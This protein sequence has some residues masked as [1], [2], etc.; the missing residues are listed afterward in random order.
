MQ[1]IIV[2][3]GKVGRALTAQLSREDNNV[4]VVDINA[5]MVRN[6]STIY[7]VMGI[8]GNGTSY[9]VLA[10]A[11]IEHT[12]ILI[13]VTHSDE[14]NLL[15][16]VVA[17]KAANCHTIARIRNPVYSAERG[18]IRRELGLSMT[19][20]PEYAA[21]QE[22]ARLLRFPSAIDIDSFSKG[23]IEMLRFKVP[24]SS[25]LIGHALKN[26]PQQLQL[27]VLVCAAERKEEV[28][29]PDGDFSIQAG[30]I[31]SIIAI[32]GNAS[33]FFHRIGIHT[34]QVKN[35]LIIGGGEITY[36]LT[37]ILLSMGIQV[38]IIEKNRMRC[39]E[40]SELLPKA[41]IIYGDGSDQDLL[42]EEHLEQMDALVASTDIDEENIILSLYAK[43]KV[44]SKV[45]TK[46]NHLDFNDVIHSLNLD[47]LIYPKNITAEYILQ[48][49]RAMR[50]S[51][52]SNVET[53]YKLMDGRVEALEFIINPLSK[54]TGIK[55][56][57]MRLK[58]NLLI[59]GIGRKGKFIIPGG[60]DEF[61]PGDSVIVVTTNSGFQDIHDILEK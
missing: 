7:D 31:L 30:D 4:T 43:G 20:N 58:K 54:M 13:A 29:I 22:I 24:E 26:L 10:D 56:Q 45:V 15:C 23:R 14:V 2:G 11:D 8:V 44:K 41:T 39:E 60:Q 42:N 50:N 48:Y 47:S 51:V 61:Q 17:K 27:D 40:L 9:H 35:A 53:L 46:L 33:V 18:F 6:V 37:V 19:I 57:D 25:S 32:P 12:D 36:Y 52:G 16:C 38:K 21:A 59:A 28:V 55:F 3:C 34:N 1:I 49:V 5:D